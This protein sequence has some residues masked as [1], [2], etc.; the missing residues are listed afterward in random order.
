MQNSE[1]KTAVNEGIVFSDDEEECPHPSINNVDNEVTM[2]LEEN[3]HSIIR[4]FKEFLSTPAFINSKGD[5]TTRIIDLYAK[6]CYNIPDRK[7]SKFFKFIE[8]MRRKKLK[9]ML[10]EKQLKYSGIM[11]DF[12]FKLNHGGESQVNHVHYHRLCIEVFKVILKY[13]QFSEDQQGTQQ[14]FHV[15]FTKKPKV[16]FN[17]EGGYYKD[18]I[19]MIIP[20]IQISRELKKLIIDTILESNC[21]DKAFKDIT[22]YESVT[23]NDFLDMNS[24]HVGVFFIGSASKVNSPAYNLDSIYRVQVS[25]GDDDDI[26]PIKSNE[27]MN[28]EENNNVCHEF[29]LNWLKLKNGVIKKEKYEIKSEYLSLL[30]QYTA[31]KNENYDEFE[32]ED[33]SHYGELS[34][35]GMSDP[36]M[37]YIKS[38]LDILHT[39]RSEDYSLWMDVLCALA[40]TSPSYKPLGE[41]F[42]RKS[43]EQFDLAKFEQTW[44]SILAKKGNS[45][46]IGSLHFWARQDNP[47]RYEEVR[48]RSISN[49]LY[50]KIYDPCVEGALEHYDLAEILYNVL[51]D[52]YVYDRTSAES[53]GTWYEFILEKEPMKTGELYKWR[54]YNKLPNSLLRY[55]ST[56]LPTLFRKILDRIKKSLD[57]SSENLAK[58]HYQIYKNFQK[59]C[60]NLKN[61][62][63]KRSAG[64]ECEQLFERIG[65]AELLDADPNLKGVANGI[66]QLGKKC[67]LITGFHGHYISK[68]TKVKFKELNPH[69]PITKKILIALRNLFP[70]DEPDVFDYIMHYLAST[71]DGHKKESIMML[72]VGKGSNGKSFLVELH[73]EAIGSI[74]GVKMPLSFL[75]NRSKDA[76]S[77]T[78]ALMQLKDAHFAYYSESNKFEIL[79]MAKIKEFTGQ[80]TLGGRKLHQEYVNFKPKCHHLVA[81]NN[82][83]EILGTDHGTWRRIDY[84][85]MK[86]KFCNLSTDTYDPKNKYERVADASL[87]SNWTEDSE[88]LASYLGILAYYYESLHTKYD[89]KVRNVPHPHIIKETE[90]FRNRQ[91]RINN[92]I[93]ASLVK[94]ED[95]E[96]EMPLTSVRDRYI[97]WH[98]SLYT[99]ASKDYHRG[100]LGQLENSKMQKFIRKN[101]R[102]GFLHGYR[103]LEIGEDI[104]E[105]EEF[106]IELFEKENQSKI[107]IKSESAIEFHKRLIVEY[108]LQ[109]QGIF[110]KHTPQNPKTTQNAESDSDSDIEEIIQKAVQQEPTKKIYKYNNINNISKLDSNGISISKKKNTPKILIRTYTDKKLHEEFA[111][112]GS[113]SDSDSDSYAELIE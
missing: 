5:D 96:Y 98:E 44:T 54:S 69:D 6:K 40:H 39:K 50:K 16:L 48:H 93:N 19:H 99:G 72:L 97:K 70:D 64:L 37:S 52:K 91:D 43:P 53:L 42:S 71:L 76:E 20:G 21:M 17:S 87:G 4:G 107:K 81:S 85:T 58:Y 49:L 79:N 113:E 27:F 11:L 75:T 86:I 90:A 36:D 30:L 77:A 12:D 32:E 51:K 60:R 38:L 73:K 61:S 94:C 59:S 108:D 84:V 10:Y 111:S 112:I 65:F 83:F 105:D 34:I 57:E 18:G 33:D 45:L 28:I 55:M 31:N 67:K 8:I 23:R 103:V 13:I 1:E 41:Y 25:I 35:L 63:F 106:Y 109:Q 78:P 104:K 14:S 101:T 56:I 29:S 22:P 88:V 95:A 92:F 47:D 7:M 68:Y 62:G 80:E 110:K 26:I 82:D 15:C 89:G 102:G 2:R 9:M 46:S 100:I 3:V 66:L 74:Y 24:A